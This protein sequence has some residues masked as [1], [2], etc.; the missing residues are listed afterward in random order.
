MSALAITG[1][2]AAAVAVYRVI[3]PARRPGETVI[4]RLPV[5]LPAGGADFAGSVSGVDAAAR[6]RMRQLDQGSGSV[7]SREVASR[8]GVEQRTPV[9]DYFEPERWDGLS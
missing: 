5:K 3:R 2:S 9:E 8:T 4:L 6:L 1:M 7:T